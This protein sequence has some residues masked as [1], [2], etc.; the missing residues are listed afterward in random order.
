MAH[1][2]PALKPGRAKPGIGAGPQARPEAQVPVRNPTSHSGASRAP[3]AD[4]NQ[5]RNPSQQTLLTVSGDTTDEDVYSHSNLSDDH[6]HLTFPDSRRASNAS[7]L[8]ASDPSPLPSRSEDSRQVEFFPGGQG[9]KP[10]QYE[11]HPELAEL[12]SHH[13]H[14]SLEPCPCQGLS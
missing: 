2:A 5:T 3:S 1:Q 6:T 8:S 11:N 7:A 9:Q 14:V 12:E 4:R 13:S 10:S